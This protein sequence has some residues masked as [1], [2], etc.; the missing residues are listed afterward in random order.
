MSLDAT[1]QPRRIRTRRVAFWLTPLALGLIEVVLLAKPV[2]RR[3][4]DEN[5][6]QLP[7]LTKDLIGVPRVAPA[8]VFGWWVLLAMNWQAEW[9]RRAAG[10]MSRVSLVAAFALAGAAVMAV[11]LPTIGLLKGLSK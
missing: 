10:V 3:Y 7:Q 11:C 1:E 2:L 5:Q 8:V 6:L 9:S 4:W